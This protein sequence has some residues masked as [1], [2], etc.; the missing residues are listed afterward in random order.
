M[1]EYM[2]YKNDTKRNSWKPKIYSLIHVY[3]II[4]T[5]I[6]STIHQDLKVFVNYAR[7]W[8]HASY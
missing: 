1:D 3:R 5:Y 8:T 7:T 2:Q 4:K 6:N